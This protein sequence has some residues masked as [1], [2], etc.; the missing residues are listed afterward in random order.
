MSSTHRLKRKPL[1]YIDVVRSFGD[2]ETDLKDA[3]KNLAQSTV[4]LKQGFDS[5]ATQLHSVDIQA[6]MPPIKPQ[7]DLTR[8]GYMEL[9]PL[10]RTNASTCSARI[11]MFCSVILP[12]SVRPS[13]GQS[14]RAYREKHHVLQS[15]M[16]IS[17]EQAALTFQLVQ[18]ATALNAMTS[19][20][21]TEIAR[22]TSQRASSGQRELQD[23]A[24]KILML[25][26]NVQKC[27]S[28][29]IKL[30]DNDDRR[31]SLYS[32][33]FK[34]SCP[35]VTY[36]AFTAFRLVATAGRQ[37]A[38]AKLSRYPLTL[39]NSDLSEMSNLFQDLNGTQSEVAH[40]QYT[41][42]I[43]HR[44]SDVLSKARIATSDLVPNQ[45]LLLEPIL[46]LVTAIWLRLQGDSLDVL[47]WVQNNREPPPCISTYLQGG[48]TIYSALANCL[49]NFVEVI[50]LQQFA[51]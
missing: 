1:S 46:S 33:S 29:L 25:Q 3:C 41:T 31:F 44:K 26:N 39:D 19:K 47:N 6:V 12:L 43:S 28:P 5:I 34:L 35:D 50:D 32:A 20:F 15:F 9:V 11:K 45:I 23:L 14:S 10:L 49:D 8:R 21:H 36:V 17:A 42:Q 13:S 2:L 22:A 38:K 24:Q 18:K 4:Q 40:A 30:K 16:T 51:S 27:V 37:S 7:W 48:H